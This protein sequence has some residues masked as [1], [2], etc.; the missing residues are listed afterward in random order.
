M[1]SRGQGSSKGVLIR[2][3]VLLV[4]G[5][6]GAL[7]LK[8]RGSPLTITEAK[9]QAMLDGNELVG[10]TVPQAA[11]KLQHEPPQNCNNNAA[12]GFEQVEGWTAG[13]VI[14]EVDGGVVTKAYWA[15][16]APKPKEE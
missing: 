16:D 3:L 7:Y 5:G 4:L 10:L 8:F 6:G 1:S 11:K 2:L 13:Q 9:V 15:K 14:L 12:F